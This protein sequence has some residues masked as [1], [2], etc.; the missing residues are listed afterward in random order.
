MRSISQFKNEYEFLSNFYTSPF[1]YNGYCWPTVE[2]AYQAAKARFPTERWLIRIAKSPAIAKKKG[3]RIL[4]RK[5]WEQVKVLI[6]TELVWLK[7]EYNPT[8]RDKLLDTDSAELMEGNY[9]HDN[10]WGDC[11]CKKCEAW[12]GQNVLGFILEEV[13][14]NYIKES[15]DTIPTETDA[16]DKEEICT[17]KYGIAQEY[18]G[19]KEDG[20]A[21]GFWDG[22]DPSLEAMLEVDGRDENSVIW[23]FNPDGTDD[24][25]YRWGGD[26]W[27]GVGENA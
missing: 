10:F 8:L 20:D 22:P 6:M 17:L 23:Q 3:R 21:Y 12:P 4:L 25:I 5:D 11:F 18:L 7:F 2:H 13:R 26:V 19:S 1:V 16:F 27:I 15:I 24:L 14:K 9:W